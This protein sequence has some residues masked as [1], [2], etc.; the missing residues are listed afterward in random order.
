MHNSNF[1]LLPVLRLL[2]YT[3]AV[4]PCPSV[5]KLSR[6]RKP[7]EVKHK[8]CFSTLKCFRHAG[9]LSYSWK[10]IVSYTLSVTKAHVRVTELYPQESVIDIYKI[11]IFKHDVNYKTFLNIYSE[12]LGTFKKD[13]TL[14]NV[15]LAAV[16]NPY[17]FYPRC[18]KRKKLNVSPNPCYRR[19]CT[20]W[21]TV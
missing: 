1:S 18:K 19:K 21:E 14:L 17:A 20:R 16:P 9:P 6:G 15:L 8:L 11:R 7:A 13:L 4:H 3:W 12:D 2:L 5:G 10:T